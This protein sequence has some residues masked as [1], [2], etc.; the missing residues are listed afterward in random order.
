MGWRDRC[1][2]KMVGV[3]AREDGRQKGDRRIDGRQKD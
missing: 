2:G 1:G 3:D